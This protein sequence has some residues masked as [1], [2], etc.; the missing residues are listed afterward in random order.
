MMKILVVIL[1]VTTLTCHFCKPAQNDHYPE[2][3]MEWIK[4][5]TKNNKREDCSYLSSEMFTINDKKIKATLFAGSYMTS[6][7]EK[8]SKIIFV[9]NFETLD[10]V[11]MEESE[12]KKLVRNVVYMK[13]FT[14]TEIFGDRRDLLTG[15]TFEEISDK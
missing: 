14:L 2:N 12:Y 10:S 5:K 15:Y 13:R 1:S 9:S 11:A 3:M 8:S 7:M 4:S 6:F